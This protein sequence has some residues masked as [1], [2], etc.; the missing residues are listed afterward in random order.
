M[1]LLSRELFFC[2]GTH[3][4]TPVYQKA[5]E[6]EILALHLQIFQLLPNYIIDLQS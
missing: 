2:T 3:L 5:G 6:T 4:R 1:Q